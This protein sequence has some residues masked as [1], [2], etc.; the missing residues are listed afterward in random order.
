M[1]EED[2]TGLTLLRKPFPPE[3]IGKLP[4]VNCSACTEANKRNRGDT[5]AKHQKARCSV[6]NNYMTTGH[7]HLDYVGHAEVTD[8]LLSA[9]PE[10]TWEPFAI[11]VDGLPATNGTTLWIRMTV[12]GVTRI[13]VGSVDAK[14]F[15]AE[16][17][18]ISDAIRNAAMR[19]GVALDLWA[20][21]DL[22]ST[23]TDASTVDPLTGEIQEGEESGGSG[24]L[25][26]HPGESPGAVVAPRAAPSDI[27]NMTARELAEELRNRGLTPTGTKAELRDRL[28]QAMNAPTATELAEATELFSDDPF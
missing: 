23:L 27:D 9:D 11:D 22:E 20:K 4:K 3:M 17:Q 10:W 14:A 21:N 7:I 15:D 28:V 19:F 5:C 12:C 26:S 6:C 1:S 18:L 16:K 24:A 8:R 25:A 2:A 13:G